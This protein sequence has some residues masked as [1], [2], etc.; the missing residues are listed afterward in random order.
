MRIIQQLEIVLDSGVRLKVPSS[1]S[2]D[3]LQF[4]LRV[5][6][7]MKNLGRKVT[8]IRYLREKLFEDSPI[9]ERWGL[10]DTKNIVDELEAHMIEEIR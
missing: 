9:G 3:D 2:A 10:N 8:A 4:H 6:R 1:I 5:A 7:V